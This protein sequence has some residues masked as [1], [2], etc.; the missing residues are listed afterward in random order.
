MLVL[1]L[2]CMT[3]P[4]KNGYMRSLKIII[5]GIIIMSQACLNTGCQQNPS[6][7]IDPVKLEEARE[8]ARETLIIDTHMDTPY[9][10]AKEDADVSERTDKGHFDYVRAREGGLDAV[11]MAV[12]ID[13]NH[14]EKGD[15]KEF[16]NNT[17]D[18]VEALMKKHPDKFTFASTPREIREHFADKSVTLLLGMENGAPLEGDLANLDYFYNRGIRYITLCH[19]KC[20][21]ICDSSF[22]DE[23]K[24]H[25]LS[26]F[27]RELVAAMNR[28]GIIIDVS[29]ISDETFYQVIE[30]SKAPVVATHSCCRHFTPGMERNMNDDMIE[31]L[32]ARGGVIQINF[33]AMFVSAAVAK[34]Y[35]KFKAQVHK[36]V[37]AK[38]LKDTARDQYIH[39][40]WKEAD[41]DPAYV[42]DVANNIDHVVKL[43]GSDY[44]GLGSDFD[45][46][47]NLPVGL[48]DVSCYPNLIAELLKRGYSRED[49]EKIC[50]GNF[51][52]VW[53]RII[54][55]AED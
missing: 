17:I 50:S 2:R 31:K 32:A 10:L 13:P 4:I 28:K 16:A 12:Y 24:W 19:S 26:P 42:S 47:S 38:G 20:N 53:Q 37:E 5:L 51:L 46:V 6:F 41:F 55:A 29:H 52:R 9:Q 1:L 14:E 33:G 54:D 30:L 18:V 15:A 34:Q 11:F 22:D 36:E 35:E 23:S 7:Q 8:F 25:G 48:S 49:I 45:G 44:V 40:R 27:G 39:A 3:P 21:H 43:V